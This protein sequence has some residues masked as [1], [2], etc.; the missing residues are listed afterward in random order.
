MWPSAG[1][2]EWDARQ[3][4]ERGAR[5]GRPFVP[6]PWSGAGARG[7]GAQRRAKTWGQRFWLLLSGARSR[8]RQK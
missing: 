3:D 2:A 5:V 6:C 7:P 8:D 4:A 1:V